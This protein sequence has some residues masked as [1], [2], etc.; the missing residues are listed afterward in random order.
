MIWSSFLFCLWTADS[1]ITSSKLSGPSFWNIADRNIARHSMNIPWSTHWYPKSSTKAMENY[2]ERGSASKLS[3]LEDAVVSKAMAVSARD[4]K[5]IDVQWCWHVHIYI[6]D[7]YI[8]IYIW[9]V[10][11]YICMIYTC[12]HV[13]MY[14]YNIFIEFLGCWV[15]K[16][17]QP[18]WQKSRRADDV[19]LGLNAA[20]SRTSDVGQ[21]KIMAKSWCLWWFSGILWW[22]SV[23]LSWLNGILWWFSVMFMVI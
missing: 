8:Y 1:G 2:G 4:K 18:L 10:Y 9:Y 23:I 17:T 21:G 11:I 5:C 20:I 19:A 22:F 13:C 14:I 12:V 16:E 6:Y 7:M 3:N 15:R